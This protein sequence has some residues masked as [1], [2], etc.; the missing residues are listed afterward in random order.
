MLTLIILLLFL[1]I[2]LYFTVV[3]DMFKQKLWLGFLGLFLFPF[4]YYHAF[5]N[6][7]GNKLRMGLLLV[8]TTLLPLTY[9]QLELSAARDELK[10]FLT[11]V[12]ASNLLTCS[13]E[14]SVMSSGGITFYTLFC[15]SKLSKNLKYTSESELVD[16]YWKNIIQPALSIY[17]DSFGKIEG[18]GVVIGIKS[19]SSLIACYKIEN[20]GNVMEAWS[21]GLS[22]PCG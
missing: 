7:S 4:T 2:V 8:V 20:P 14:P 22:E 15:A 11:S 12:D 5:K 21:S 18:K 19:P 3:V 1:G 16:V 9:I 10:P 6:Y 17:R 13:I